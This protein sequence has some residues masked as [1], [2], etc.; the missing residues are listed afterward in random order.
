MYPI[1]IMLLPEMLVD[2]EDQSPQ[3]WK[4]VFGF[5]IPPGQ[6]IGETV[7][8]RLVG[9]LQHPPERGTPFT[10]WNT[11]DE[12]VFAITISDSEPPR[13]DIKPGGKVSLWTVALDSD[14]TGST[15][16]EKAAVIVNAGWRLVCD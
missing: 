8:I 15:P 2:V 16:A 3:I 11:N 1:E 10:F 4:D 14:L 12:P 13:R 7:I 6:K 9:E 5:D